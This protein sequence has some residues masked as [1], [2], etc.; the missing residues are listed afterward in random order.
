MTALTLQLTKPTHLSDDEFYDFC[1]ANADLRIERNTKGE[2]IIMPPTGGET[3]RRNVSIILQLGNW[4]QQAGIGEVFDLSTAFKL[5]NGAD[6]SPGASWITSKRWNT[7]TTE[8][9]E[10]FPPICPDFVV[11]L[12]SASDRLAP[13]QSKML[14]YIDNGARLGWLINRQDQQVEI[15]RPNRTTEVLTNP[16]RLSGDLVLKGFELKLSGIL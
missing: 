5:P 14:E 13:L 15:Y 1:R 6:R 16:L 9:K 3:G 11:E 4:N 10:K 7:L 2:L 8:Q 12:R